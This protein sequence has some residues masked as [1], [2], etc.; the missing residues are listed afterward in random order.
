MN[1]LTKFSKIF[2]LDRVCRLARDKRGVS[3]V[4][5]ALVFPL[6]VGLYLGLAEVA[7][8][9]GIDRK[10]S[11]TAR[12]LSDLCSQ[13]SSTI[14]NADMTNILNATTSVMSPYST[15][16]LTV[17]VSAINIDSTGKATVGWS[18][19]RG[20]TAR[21]VGSTITIPSALAIP[22]TQLILSEVTYGYKPAIGYTITGTLTLSEKLYMS[23]RVNNI[24]R[25]F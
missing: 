12:A 22:S 24:T 6:M 16:P 23:P 17:V 7:Q 14:S 1:C 21:S 4:E 3:A 10:V 11:L 19:T 25:T 13:A 9:V 15:T 2:R 18:D 8:G 20:G 5:F